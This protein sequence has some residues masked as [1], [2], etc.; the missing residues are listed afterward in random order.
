VNQILSTVKL[1]I[2]LLTP[3]NKEQ[4]GIKVKT[5]EYIMMAIEEIRK[6]SREMVVPQ[7][8]GGTLTDNIRKVKD[9]I[10]LS[11][12]VKIQFT[13]DSENELLS[14]KKLT[15]FRIIAGAVK[16]ILKYSRAKDIQIFCNQK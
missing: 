3:V 15:L 13:H 7:L 6:L 4:A 5:T 14:R 1:F 2:D 12:D 11:S 10:E 9:D 16:N 8:D